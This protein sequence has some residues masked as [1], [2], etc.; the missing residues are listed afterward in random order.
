MSILALDVGKRRI[1][2]AV[3]GPNHIFARS[4]T[5]ICVRNRQQSLQAIQQLVEQE[6]ATQVIVGHPLNMDGSVGP[7]ARHAESFARQL[8]RVLTIPVTLWDERLSTVRAQEAMIEAGVPR[9]ARRTRLDAAAAAAILQS[10]LDRHQT[11]VRD[12]GTWHL[13]P[14]TWHLTP[15]T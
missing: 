8:A 10:Y 2:V 14:G 13:A 3:S 4:L 9:K 5:V 11:V 15:D 7:Q 6:Q 1:G 12:S